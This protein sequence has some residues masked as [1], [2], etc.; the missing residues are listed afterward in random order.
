MPTGGGAGRGP[1][2]PRTRRPRASGGSA[3]ARR[4]HSIRDRAGRFRARHRRRHRGPPPPARPGRWRS[5]L[6]G[7]RGWRRAA[8]VRPR[9]RRRARRQGQARRG[10]GRSRDASRWSASSESSTAR[11]SSSLPPAIIAR[12]RPPSTSGIGGVHVADLGED[13]FGAR[14]VALGEHL[15]AHRDQRLDL[16]GEVLRG[17]LDG[18]LAEQLVEHALQ[19]R[20]GAICGEVGDGLAL[21]ES[22]DRRDRLDLELRGEELVGL[23]VDLGEDHALVGIIG[24]ELVEDRAQLLARPAPF[25]PEI[26]DHEAGHRR[27]DDV[28]LEALDRLPFVLA[29]PES[30]HACLL[31]CGPAYGDGARERQAGAPWRQ[32]VADPRDRC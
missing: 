15:L 2:G 20:L 30:R 9:R 27:L 3:C 6:H 13:R 5:A 26:E 14:G 21:E 31:R 29:H 7:R 11:A 19:L 28:A 18:Q 10:R 24:G 16:R 32:G 12:A 23:D 1:T 8:P 22:V 4:R 17:S 25:G